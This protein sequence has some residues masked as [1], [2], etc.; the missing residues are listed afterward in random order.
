MLPQLWQERRL[1]NDSSLFWKEGLRAQSEE[2]GHTKIKAVMTSKTDATGRVEVEAT[3]STVHQ[4]PRSEIEQEPQ[5]QFLMTSG[6][7]LIAAR[8]SGMSHHRYEHYPCPIPSQ[9]GKSDDACF[10]TP[11]NH[12]AGLA[13]LEPTTYGLGNRRS[14]RLSY[15]PIDSHYG[16]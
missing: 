5:E 16:G 14:I 12:L 7:L 4:P 3:I 9:Q 6:S 2:R 1:R 13:G 8:A 11:C 15:S 10:K